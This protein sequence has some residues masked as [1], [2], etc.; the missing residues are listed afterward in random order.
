MSKKLEIV[1][2]NRNI[3]EN[4]KKECYD[5]FGVDIVDI[6]DNIFSLDIKKN[7]DY[8]DI[9]YQIAT[10]NHLDM[11]ELMRPNYLK[12]IVVDD[13]KFDKDKLLYIDVTVKEALDDKKYILYFDL[14]NNKILVEE[15][16]E[17]GPNNEFEYKII[18]EKPY[19]S[20]EELF[21]G[22]FKADIEENQS[23]KKVEALL[24]KEIFKNEKDNNSRLIK[25]HTS[26]GNRGITIN[27]DNKEFSL[28]RYYFDNS[29]ITSYITLKV[30]KKESIRSYA[31]KDFEKNEIYYKKFMIED[32]VDAYITAIGNENNIES[33][34]MLYDRIQSKLINIP[35]KYLYQLEIKT[36]NKGE[37]GKSDVQEILTDTNGVIS[38]STNENVKKKVKNRS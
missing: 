7:I 35:D 19:R 17:I 38:I 20:I 26:Q 29:K 24:V 2:G 12:S 18:D 13:Y 4:I 14:D 6:L 25:L 27:E 10:G 36:Q 16:K 22:H 9:R 23:F 34:L 15:D 8:Q 33:S 11:R 1:Y 21:D 5:F 31:Y 32:M 28:F 30:E 3:S 37:F